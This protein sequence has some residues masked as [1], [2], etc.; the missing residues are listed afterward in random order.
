MARVFMID[1]EVSPEE[2]RILDF[3]A[4]RPDGTVY[5]GASPAGFTAFVQ[6]ADFLCGHNIL[7]HDLPYLRRMTDRPVPAGVIDTLYLSPL[8]FPKK[9][10]H[11]LLKDD[12]LQTEEL[13][14]PVNDCLKAAQLFRDE[15]AAF[16]A[17]PENVRQVYRGLLSGREEF[18]GFFDYL[19]AEKREAGRAVRLS[20]AIRSAW[21]GLICEHADLDALIR[22]APVELAYA[23]ALTAARDAASLTP[24]WVL[25]NY[26]RTE[27]VIKYLCG[28]PCREGCS[29]C[30]RRLDIHAGLRRIFG[31]ADFRTYEGEPLQ[32]RAVRAAVEGKSL[33]A[34]FPTG[35][36]KSVTFQLPALLAGETVHGLTVVIS[37]LQSLMKDQVDHLSE[38]GI[39][40]AVTLNGLMSPVERADACRRVLSGSASLLFIAPEQLRSRT[41]ERMLL[42]RNVVRFVIDEAHCFSAWGQDF[43]VDYLYIGD[44]IAELQRKKNH[45]KPIPVSCFTA[46][47]K[48]KVISDIRD[49]FHD[50]LGLE[51]ELFA[52]RAERENLHY[53][54]LF[55]ETDEAKYNAL[56]SLLSGRDVPAIVYVSRTK[57]TRDLAERL[58]HDGFPARPFNGKM[59]SA[60]KIENQEAFLRNEVR[61]MVATSA[62]GMG[63]DKKDVGLVIHYD[64]SDSLENYIQEAGRAGRDPGTRAECYVLYNNGDLD[65]HFLLLNQTKLS[66]GEIQQVWKAVKDLT[67]SRPQ[68]CC[69]PLEIA[70][71]A[72]WETSGPEMETRVRTAVAAL[73]NAGY[74]RRGQNVPHVYASAIQARTMSE[75]GTRIRA[76][77]LFSEE[78]KRSALRILSFLISRRS[79]A[80]AGNDD[81]ESRVDY[82]ADILGL[83][84]QEVVESIHLMRREGLL[85]DARDMSAWLL[86]SD[87]ENRSAQLLERY[88]RLENFLLGR[89]LEMNGTLDLKRINEAAAEAGVPSGIRE[90]RTILYFWTVKNW[91]QKAE[92]RENGT[93]ETVLT[94]EET[95]LW[96]RLSRRAALARFAVH[97]LFAEAGSPPQ[98]G[99]EAVPV[100]FSLNGLFEAWEHRNET[101]GQLEMNTVTAEL[102]DLEDALLYLSKIGAMRLEGGFLVLYNGMEIQR[103]KKDNRAR[104]KVE[105]YRLLNEFYR[106]KIQQIHIVGEYANMMVRDY[107]EALRFVRDYFRMEYREFIRKY[108]KGERAAEINLNITRD[109]YRQIFGS[110]SPVQE[111]IIQNSQS[112]VLAVAAGPGSG[113]TR[114]LVHKLASL[115][116]MEDVKHEQLLMLTFSRAAATEFRKRL[117]ALIG[118]AAQ[119]VEMKTFHSYAFDLL[120]KPGT[121]EEADQVIPRAAAMIRNGEAEPGR[122]AKAVLVIDEAQDMD[123]EDF[124]LVRALMDRNE[125]MRVIAVGDDDQ[126]I[127]EFR[128][129]DSGFLRSLAE[130]PDARLYEMVQ[131]YRSAA[132]VVA[133]EN[134]F[135][136]RMTTRLKTVPLE[137]VSASPGRVRI[138]REAGPSF[139]R[140][141]AEEIRRRR[142]PGSAAV[143]TATN[144][145]ALR[146]FTQLR[147][148]GIRAKLIQS[149]DGFRLSNLI[150]IRC[151][152]DRL[153][154]AGAG[155]VIPEE[156][157]KEARQAVETAW[158]ESRNLEICRNLWRDFEL[159]SP[160]R[161][162]SDLEEFLRESNP[163]DFYSEEREAVQVSTIHKAKGREYDQVWMMLPGA[164][165]ETEEEKR[166]LYVGMSRAREE[167]YIH[168][169]TDLFDGLPVTESLRREEREEAPAEI[170]LQLTHRDVVLS[171]FRDR[172][173]RTAALYAGMPLGVRM[174]YLTAEAGGRSFPAAKLSA[175]AVSRLA[176][177]EKK[178]YR[179]VSASVRMI[180]AWKAEEDP[181]EC[182][183]M[184]PE[185]NLVRED[186]RDTQR[187]GKEAEGT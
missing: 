45:R 125:D 23:L 108:F 184:L 31:Y 133:L 35:G 67:R 25:R 178:G 162:R 129:S 32:E 6:G 89:M 61:I 85:S 39:T 3:G 59:Q 38:A 5:H 141:V 97:A 137:A 140:G 167:L 155:P 58:T 4:V 171:F 106:Q 115:L 78:Q 10:Y 123:A 186:A 13:N 101:A 105:D 83:E 160:Q 56:R 47:A 94:L 173:E 117:R 16:L 96:N 157:W 110:L 187:T 41:V 55:E 95:E 127:Y 176:E 166:R 116:L 18:R 2:G 136:A 20:D 147:R 151:F 74:V 121:L 92:N 51:L 75:A 24:P 8:L 7:R 185:V 29:Y 11:A 159:T 50:R 100:R 150:E 57:R 102:S 138:V 21:R 68:V 144:E 93:V 152:L 172:K 146:I 77:E 148:E 180:V 76:S 120:G 98:D 107:G 82:L 84:K 64:I 17:L 113:K 143:L 53:T 112:R 118:N 104:Y 42:S 124:S 130:R 134:A 22:H 52:S 30:A 99:G 139:E 71:Q 12:K 119:F 111:E 126:N 69:S 122:I 1:T 109:K 145:E 156:V 183:V 70:R 36:G 128:G 131:N 163:D 37:P 177:L 182:W 80:R 158:P 132:S 72:G 34:V 174:P 63:V 153:D 26:P 164:R 103:L 27:N 54:V 33:L 28:T 88:L 114:V 73:E 169:D 154:A 179:P 14:N 62:F 43:R 65:R 168:T 87:T 60:E 15:T 161:Y 19:A 91:I 48:P 170:S 49:Y 79:A 66:I 165:G 90:L 86:K 135:A 46:T 81:A 142:G 149:L 44:F 9:P 175:A 181:E 40:G